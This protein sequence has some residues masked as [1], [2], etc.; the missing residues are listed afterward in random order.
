M[1]ENRVCRF[2]ERIGDRPNLFSRFLMSSLPKELKES[3]GC[4]SCRSQWV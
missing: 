4:S 2:Y 3:A 1:S